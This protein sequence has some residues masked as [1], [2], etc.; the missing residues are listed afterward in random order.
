MSCIDERQGEWKTIRKKKK[1][2]DPSL[3]SITTTRSRVKVDVGEK[4]MTPGRN[5]H[6]QNRKE[7]TIRNLVDGSQKTI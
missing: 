2:Q 4:P 7:E 1:S 3:L 6:S 5:S